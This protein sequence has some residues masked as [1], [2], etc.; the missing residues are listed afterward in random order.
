VLKVGESLTGSDLNHQITMCRGR[1][2]G[3]PVDSASIEPH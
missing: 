1:Y 3:G 2:S